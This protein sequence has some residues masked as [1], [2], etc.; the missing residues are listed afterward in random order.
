M[1]GM[2]MF[3]AR[4]HTEFNNAMNMIAS[5]GSVKY[6][7]PWDMATTSGRQYMS[8]AFDKVGRIYAGA[9]LK[10]SEPKAS[11]LHDGT[12]GGHATPMQKATLSA[13]YNSTTTAEF[14]AAVRA[15][16]KYGA[17][18][19]AATSIFAQPVGVRSASTPA[20]PVARQVSMDIQAQP[21]AIATPTVVTVDSAHAT[22]R[23][24]GK[25]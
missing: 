15:A 1:P 24:K 17:I 23:R 22:K 14:N 10:Q 11:R 7:E 12:S 3:A 13:M 4:N 2:R 8:R 6:S 25:K 20:L 9:R 5:T 18:N 21:A 19:S 16:A